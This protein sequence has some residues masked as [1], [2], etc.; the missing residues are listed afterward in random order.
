MIVSS[1]LCLSEPTN[2]IG[3]LQGTQ[4]MTAITKAQDDV[5]I[6]LGLTKIGDKGVE[7]SKV[8]DTEASPKFFFLIINHV[9]S[10][11]T[12]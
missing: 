11:V 10:N 7:D 12:L 4:N 3:N 6:I 9:F 5:G 1:V 8:L 2:M